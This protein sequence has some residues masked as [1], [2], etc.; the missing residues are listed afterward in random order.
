MFHSLIHGRNEYGV[1][2]QCRGE[3]GGKGR[4]GLEWASLG[5]AG[6]RWDFLWKREGRRF[7]K[8][9]RNRR[10]SASGLR[11]SR[12]GWGRA[13]QENMKT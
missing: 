10:V 11:L 12:L 1:M 9:R 3:I 8:G 6:H 5:I 2:A 13:G 7:H 4:G